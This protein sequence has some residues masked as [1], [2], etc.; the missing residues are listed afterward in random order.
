[1]TLRCHRYLLLPAALLLAVARC[2]QPKEAPVISSIDGSRSVEAR[3]SADYRCKATDP[4]WKRLSYDWSQEGGSLAWDW[5]ESVRWYA[6]DFSGRGVIKVTVTDEDGL[7]ATDSL[8]VTVRAETVGVLSWDA[9]IKAG[10][11]WSWHDSI[12][13]GYKLY[14][15]C[16][17]DTG[18][19]FLMVMDDSNFARWRAGEPAVPLLRR[20]PYIRDTF[21]LKISLLGLYHLVVD[22]TV[23]AEDY[24]YF[25]NVWK[26]GP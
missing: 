11:Y 26:A 5:G 10:G 16:G 21:S 1:M 18:D 19:I 15:R 22:N 20:L 9:A 2:P 4:D 12:R 13:A 7:A 25:L 14:G 8:S 17:S 24:N 3:D 6:P 23:G